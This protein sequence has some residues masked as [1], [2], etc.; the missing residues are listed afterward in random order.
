[1][2]VDPCHK[3]YILGINASPLSCNCFLFMFPLVIMKCK[4]FHGPSDFKHLPTPNFL[5]VIRAGGLTPS[6]GWS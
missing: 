2:L 5:C 6:M 1:M 4:I 3:G